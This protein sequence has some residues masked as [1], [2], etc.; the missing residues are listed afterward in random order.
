VLYDDDEGDIDDDDDDDD[1]DEDG[2]ND[3]DFALLQDLAKAMYDC[4]CSEKDDI[5]NVCV[6]AFVC[7]HNDC[8]FLNTSHHT[9]PHTTLLSL[10]ITFTITFTNQQLS[11]T[12]NYHQP[13]TI[14]NQQ[15]SQQ[16]LSHNR[17]YHYICFL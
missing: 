13:T 16:Q 8:F 5:H 3:D 9:T 11:P 6:C 14:T 2:D 12:N 17:H 4:Q 1:D 15:L 10:S 7:V